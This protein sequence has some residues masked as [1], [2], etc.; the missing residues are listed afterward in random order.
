MTPDEMLVHLK[1]QAP[2]QRV[3]LDAVFK[4]CQEQVERGVTDFSFAAIARMGAGRGVPKVQ[5]IRNKT[6][7]NYRMLIKCFEGS[8]VARK[9]V[10][11][12]R[13]ADA[14]VDDIED[15]GL[16]FMVNITLC[17]LAE[18]ERLNKELIP[19][20][21][22]IRIDDRVGSGTEYRL[23]P[24]ERRAIEYLLSEDF[25]TVWQL[26]P[27]AKGT[28]VDEQGKVVFKPGTMDALT[29]ILKYL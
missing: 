9:R 13:A 20:G 23:T 28:V 26:K 14:W 11:K 25:F 24:V 15:V 29:K 3:T 21:T 19:P 18:A 5:S 22:E 12:K 10:L 8:K 2:R 6:G 1:E 7:E 16:R 4:V 27:S 17:K